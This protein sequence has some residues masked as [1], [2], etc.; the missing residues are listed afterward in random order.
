MEDFHG[1]REYGSPVDAWMDYCKATYEI[2][3]SSYMPVDWRDMRDLGAGMARYYEMW[4]HGRDILDTLYIDGVPQTE[5]NFKIPL[6]IDQETLDRVGAD[7]VYYNGTLDRVILNPYGL[8]CIGEYKTA[9]AIYKSHYLTDPQI[10]AYSWA[11]NC[12]YPGQT[13]DGVYYYQFKKAVPDEPAVLKTTGRLS[14]D[15]SKMTTTHRMYRDAMERLYGTVDAAP[16]ATIDHL[17]WLAATETSESDGF[18]CRDFIQRNEHSLQAEGLKILMEVE[19]MLNPE[20][21]LYP[22]PTRECTMFPCDFREPCIAIDEGEDW[23][24]IIDEDYE[25]RQKEKDFSWRQLLQIN[26]PEKLLVLESAP[27]P[28]LSQLRQQQLPQQLV[29]PQL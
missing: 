6:P 21:A 28:S 17:N 9:K 25:S 10:G 23:A 19:E 11:A 26:K 14:T 27:L 4:L 15:K 29:E 2:Y 12:I 18:I 1:L 7:I 13:F 22:N 8:L 20:I 3:G 24:K 16:N 5:V